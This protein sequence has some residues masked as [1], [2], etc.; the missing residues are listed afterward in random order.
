MI[1]TVVRGTVPSEKPFSRRKNWYLSNAA[2]L[3]R[4]GMLVL[5]SADLRF[6]G[7]GAERAPES[8][9]K[10]KVHST[11]YRGRK[12]THHFRPAFP[13]HPT[14]MSSLRLPRKV[15]YLMSVQ[16]IPVR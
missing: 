2:Q 1:H 7:L 15:A 4:T 11:G 5:P 10:A 16:L 6:P 13:P 8:I 12:A 3:E 9:F 14:Q